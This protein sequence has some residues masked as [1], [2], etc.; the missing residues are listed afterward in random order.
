MKSSAPTYRRTAPL[1]VPI[2]S[3]F[4]NQSSCTTFHIKHELDSHENEPVSG[5]H[6]HIDDFARR[7]ILSRRQK[8]AREWPAC[9]SCVDTGREK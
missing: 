8:E 9:V 1:D 6:F 7:L 4:Q 3:L 5:T 2:L